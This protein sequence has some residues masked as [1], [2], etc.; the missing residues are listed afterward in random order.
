MLLKLISPVSFYFL[1]N[2]VAILATKTAQVGGS[3]FKSSPR[4]KLETLYAKQIKAK[5]VGSVAQVVEHLPSMCK[6]LY[7]T[8]AYKS[9]SP[10]Y[11][12]KQGYH[13]YIAGC[14]WCSRGLGCR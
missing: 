4:Q 9:S 2:M 1:K 14:C 6:A 12:F 5:R 13:L 10:L 3:L 7:E 8:L 11:L